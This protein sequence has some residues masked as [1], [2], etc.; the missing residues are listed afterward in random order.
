MVDMREV[1]EKEISL[2]ICNTVGELCGSYY[3]NEIL[4]ENLTSTKAKEVLEEIRKQYPIWKEK[5]GV[6]QN[7][8]LMELLEK[9]NV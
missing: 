3:L 6:D 5:Y 9:L 4:P 1:L 8:T 2:G 7:T